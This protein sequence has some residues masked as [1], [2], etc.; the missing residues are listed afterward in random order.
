MT[1]E[2]RKDKMG[3]MYSDGLRAKIRNLADMT[4]LDLNRN[5]SVLLNDRKGG[6]DERIERHYG[7]N[8]DALHR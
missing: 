7:T 6:S 1:V 3:G 5:E 4:N 8:S 2:S